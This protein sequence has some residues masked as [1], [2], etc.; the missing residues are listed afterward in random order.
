MTYW[1]SL[2][3]DRGGEFHLRIFFLDMTIES[4][5]ESRLCEEGPQEGVSY[6]ADLNERR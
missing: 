3:Q 5:E 6:L 1:L 4:Q 2:S